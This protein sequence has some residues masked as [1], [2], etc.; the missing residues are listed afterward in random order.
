MLVELPLAEGTPVLRTRPGPSTL[1]VVVAAAE[2]ETQ[3]LQQPVRE[4][5]LLA[6]PT[7][8]Q[9]ELELSLSLAPPPVVVVVVQ[10]QVVMVRMAAQV[11]VVVVDQVVEHRARP[12]AATVGLL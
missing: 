2:D 4:E 3:A 8:I 9:E 5:L 7:I 1:W 12:Q 6:V 10:E 11:Q